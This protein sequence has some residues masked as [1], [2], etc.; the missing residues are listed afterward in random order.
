MMQCQDIERY[1]DSFIDCE[2]AEPERLEF[3]AHLSECAP[4]R[5]LVR[6]QAAFKATLRALLQR[7]AAP[8]G[9]RQRVDAMLDAQ[10]RAEAAPARSGLFSRSRG[11]VPAAVLGLFVLA[12]GWVLSPAPRLLRRESPV[13]LDSIVIH[14]RNLPL[15]VAGNPEAVW[16]WFD[17][18]VSFAVRV[19]H[20]EPAASLRG[21]RLVSLG[22]REAAYLTYERRGDRISVF[23]FDARDLPLM[24][25]R[26]HVVGQREIF[27]EGTRGYQVALFRDNDV[28]YAIT[29]SV[30]EP[31][32]IRLISAAV[33][34]R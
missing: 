29:G 3:E 31:E 26:R 30:A 32:L 16:R 4:C 25:P 28:G 21:G 20:L 8:P 34:E 13:I 5:E 11:W 17:G 19:P 12:L 22:S 1:V 15:D 6:R 10:E 33:S 2:F 9:L 27:T 18:K 7:P 23:V 14:Q 24:A